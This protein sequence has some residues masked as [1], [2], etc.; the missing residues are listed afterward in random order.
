MNSEPENILEQ[1]PGDDH[2]SL[3]SAIAN[4]GGGTQC[5]DPI[6]PHPKTG[7]KTVWNTTP[8]DEES[9]L[10]LTQ[11]SELDEKMDEQTEIPITTH[12]KS[13]WD[14]SEE[15]SE[16]DTID[17][18]ESTDVRSDFERVLNGPLDFKGSYYFHRSYNEFPNP[19]L[20]LDSLGHV[21]L[22]LS[23]REA[24]HIINY[25]VQAPFGQGERTL[26]DKNVRDTWEMD[27]SQVHFD[28]P[29]WETFMK[30]VGQEVCLK[31]GLAAS[32][33]STVRCE[34]YKLLLYET[35]SHFLPHQ[36]TEKAKGMF[37]TI[38]VV[39]PSSFQGGAAHLSHGDLSTVIDSSSHSLSNIS[40]LAWYTDVMH[41]IKP[42]S[43]GYRL[44]IAF[45]LIQTTNSRPKLPETSD[46]LT[47]LRNVLLS[48]KH[49]PVSNAPAK[50]IYLLQHKYSLA[51]LR[52]NCLKGADAYKVALLQSLAKQLKFDVGLANVECHLVGYGDQE[53]YYGSEDDEDVGMAEVEERSMSIENLV[54]LDGRHIQGELDCDEND[55]EFC[56]EDLR[57]IVEAG[58]PDKREYEGYQGN[59]RHSMIALN[60]LS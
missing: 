57:D 44:A 59:V 53:G 37:A 21:G 25:C 40:V 16:E 8:Q 22:P 41:E 30:Q 52:G 14:D 48:W 20:R 3:V 24:K 50:L 58:E 43:G 28:N 55:S 13:E 39:L 12:P 17:A 32:Q 35:G 46:F 7:G 47:K 51:G 45:N 6:I 1:L 49:Q 5:E 2:L 19:L 31:L 33:A 9:D 42:I 36:D 26:I 56:P 27:A 60:P 38:V 18:P 11:D 54:D 4:S 34:P 23:S 29:L 15:E 10:P